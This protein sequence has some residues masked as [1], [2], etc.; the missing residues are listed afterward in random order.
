M[1]FCLH[2]FP[3]FRCCSPPHTPIF[4]QAAHIFWQAPCFL[5]KY[6]NHILLFLFALL[7]FFTKDFDTLTTP[8]KTRLQQAEPEETHITKSRRGRFQIWF[9]LLRIFLF[10]KLSTMQKPFGPQTENLRNQIRSSE[11]TFFS[12]YR[13]D[14]SVSLSWHSFSTD[15][16]PKLKM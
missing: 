10:S 5:P 3:R 15:M 12:C 14:S 4:H 16:R 9:F 13:P 2:Y 6:C 7:L 8:F 1:S 11:K